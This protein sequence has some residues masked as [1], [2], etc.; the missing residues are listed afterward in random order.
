MDINQIQTDYDLLQNEIKVHNEII[1][2]LKVDQQKLVEPASKLNYTL[3]NH[4]F[5]I[6]ELIYVVDYDISYYSHFDGHL[7]EA[8]EYDY[9]GSYSIDKEQ[10]N[11]FKSVVEKYISNNSYK[12]DNEENSDIMYEQLWDIIPGEA[13][14]ECG[15]DP[16][17]VLQYMKINDDSII[18][19][20]TGRRDQ[21]SMNPGSYFKIKLKPISEYKPFEKS[22]D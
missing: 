5:V 1:K 7:S 11:L 6:N 9:S 2:Q 3:K 21:G 4:K 17:R 18:F 19:E 22:N 10:Y 12:I 14:D 20:K 13:M 15:Y 8:I 16:Q